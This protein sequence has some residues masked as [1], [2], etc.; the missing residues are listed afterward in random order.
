MEDTLRIGIL[1]T[2]SIGAVICDAARAV[3]NL[4]I[5]AVASRTPEKAAAFAA[6]HGIKISCSY[7]ELLAS[8][9]VDAVYVPLP[10]ALATSWAIKAAKAGKHGTLFSTTCPGSRVGGM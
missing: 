10:T 1:S 4:E 3:K 5:A 6:Q 8:T 2:A 9:A 7:D